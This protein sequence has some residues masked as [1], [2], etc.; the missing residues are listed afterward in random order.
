LEKFRPIGEVGTGCWLDYELNDMF[1]SYPDY[2]GRTLYFTERSMNDNELLNTSLPPGCALTQRDEIL[3]KQS[4]DYESTL[5]SFGSIEAVLSQTLGFVILHEGK[6]VCEAATGAPTH[7]RVEVG[8][9]THEAIV[10]ADWLQS[11]ASI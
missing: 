8:V 9:T 10:N 11:L 6:V 1:P 2:D 3:F 4:F 7:G 5:D